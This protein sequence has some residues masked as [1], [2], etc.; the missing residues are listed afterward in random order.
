M[1]LGTPGSGL[2][3][4]VA[5]GTRGRELY[6]GIAGTGPFLMQG[7]GTPT[8]NLPKASCQADKPNVRGWPDASSTDRR[9]TP[10][11][12]TWFSWHA[13]KANGMRPHRPRQLPAIAAW[14][15]IGARRRK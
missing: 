14:I 5:S 12:S 7:S 6:R 13:A 1:R 15:A 3:R 4:G 11:G 9:K 10:L 8:L 2:N